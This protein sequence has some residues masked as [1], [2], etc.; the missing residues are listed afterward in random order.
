MNAYFDVFFDPYR[1]H[2]F[3]DSIC[4][5]KTDAERCDS[6]KK[7]MKRRENE[8]RLGA[9]SSLGIQVVINFR[10]GWTHCTPWRV[11]L[12]SF[13]STFF[14]VCNSHTRTHKKADRW[15]VSDS[16]DLV[17]LHL[18]SK[19]FSKLAHDN[20]LWKKL[21][22]KSSFSPA[23]GRRREFLTGIPASISDPT[24]AQLRA[25]ARSAARSV[26]ANGTSTDCK[27]P[28]RTPTGTRH[29]RKPSGYCSV[30][31]R[32]SQGEDLN[33]YHEYIARHSPLSLSW[34]QSP[35]E[36]ETRVKHEIRGIGLVG[37]YG[38][39]VIAPLDNDSVCLWS[40][41]HDED[42]SKK[43]NGRIMARSKPGILSADGRPKTSIIPNP[44]EPE[45]PWREAIVENVSVDKFNN[46]A[47][48]AV[49]SGLNEV[50]LETLQ[51]VSHW[52]F[53]SPIC[54]LSEISH[55]DP[56]TVATTA[57][58]H[59]HDQ[60]S[61]QHIFSDARA[62]TRLDSCPVNPSKKPNDFHR[63]LSS[64]KATH[65]PLIQSPLSIV[66]LHSSQTI[67]VA[68]RF[69]SILTFD[70]RTFPR[71]HSTIH[72]GA[73]LSSLTSTSS[74]EADT[75]IACGEYKGKGSLELYHRPISESSSPPISSYQNR[76]SAA[77]SKI[78]SVAP[79]GNRIV[80]CDGDGMLKWVENDGSTLVRRWNINSFSQY[81]TPRGLF[82]GPSEAGESD[83]ARK[84]MPLNE[85]S[86]SELAIW[87]GEKIGIV[88][89]RKKP[90]FGPWDEE[91]E[92]N[93]EV[94]SRK[95]SEGVY[96]G[97]M[98]KALERQADEVRFIRGLGFGI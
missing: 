21:V 39:T 3:F 92:E 97:R 59:V 81:E 94:R 67:H 6:W 64:D 7:L 19:K 34:L 43:S 1:P 11:Y 16:Y 77:R 58:L 48:F 41:G 79:H 56:L 51:P 2:F 84:I 12:K 23:A 32:S 78:L 50:D 89:F 33:F 8:P 35:D 86:K 55:T 20:E 62:S 47:Y 60:R 24:V 82:G 91:V 49:Q 74:P 27:S 66:H 88:G 44:W 46:K 90:R 72:S 31:E 14:H 22:V 40:V 9:V 17:S 53:P 30:K 36:P 96:E 13:C 4:L 10:S 85:S 95:E 71:I 38:E 25:A 75:L 26:A 80:F 98:R 61:P 73:R 68:G 42:G 63:L 83:V 57:S 45:T 93:E 69:P 37:N 76:T 70:R 28:D 52:K 87:T 15:T 65:A 18:V 5:L 29:G 54:A